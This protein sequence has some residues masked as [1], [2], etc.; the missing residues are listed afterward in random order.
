MGHVVNSIAFIRLDYVKKWGSVWTVS[1]D[2]IQNTCIQ[3]LIYYIFK[4][5]FYTLY[6]PNFSHTY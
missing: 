6:T 2:C 4:I 3:I 1:K 5:I